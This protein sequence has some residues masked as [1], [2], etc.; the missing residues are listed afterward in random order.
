[1]NDSTT[2][3]TL[4]TPG[5]IMFMIGI[6]GTLF[7]VY[8]SITAPQISSDKKSV[9]VDDRITAIEKTVQDI[10]ETHL[11]TVEQDIKSLTA[12]VNELAKTVVRLATIIDE[13]I[14]RQNQ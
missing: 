4:L 14:P 2:I 5:N 13:R 3:A 11:K 10:K 1:M 6:L 7:T 12:S 9:R 8:R